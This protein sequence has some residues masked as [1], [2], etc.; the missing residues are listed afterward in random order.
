MYDRSSSNHPS[1]PGAR[2]VLTSTKCDLQREDSESSLKTAQP[3]LKR[4]MSCDLK[5]TKKAR[6][7]MSEDRLTALAER[8]VL[9]SSL[10]R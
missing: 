7:A 3:W 8:R 1:G 10:W 4:D 2:L 6:S 5:V 9:S